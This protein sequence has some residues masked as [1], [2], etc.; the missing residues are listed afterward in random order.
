MRYL[1]V[2]LGAAD[3]VAREWEKR[4]T[5]K[6]R[7]RYAQWA[8]RGGPRVRTV[9]GRNIV[10]RNSVMAVCWYLV[11]NQCPPAL[12]DMMAAW[13]KETWAFVERPRGATLQPGGGG[14]VHA[15]PRA[16]MVQD[17]AEGGARCLDT[18]RFTRALYMRHVR[19]LVDPV[20]QGWK[21]MAMH[22]LKQHYGVLRQGY[23]LLLSACDFLAVL[24]ADVPAFWQNVFVTWGMFDVPVPRDETDTEE[25]DP[26]ACACAQ[27]GF[28]AVWTH[29]VARVALPQTHWTLMRV[30]M[31]P[32]AYNQHLSGVWGARVLEPAAAADVLE[33]DHC[34]GTATLTRVSRARR[35]QARMVLARY[36]AVARA[37]YT[38]VLH[39]LVVDE[40]LERVR[41]KRYDELHVRGQVA[42]M[43]AVV[44]RQLVSGFPPAW[45]EV[46][47]TASGLL[48]ERIQCG[49]PCSLEDLARSFPL[50]KAVW[51][52]LPSGRV[53]QVCESTAVMEWGEAGSA[54]SPTGRLV[55]AEGSSG[56]VPR[57]HLEE[58]HIW[59]ASWHAHSRTDEEQEERRVARGGRGRAVEELVY[60]GLVAEPALL[61]G[62]TDCVMGAVHAGQWSLTYARTDRVRPPVPFVRGC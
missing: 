4:T 10:V 17:Y 60:G 18:E 57:E 42:C 47:D 6:V 53:H 1:G 55:P 39:L 29:G 33:R 16:V 40:R 22:W 30:L 21:G 15:V 24:D 44:Y 49:A 35:E 32:L 38:H 37:G 58:V 31:E 50:P 43:S 19:R 62:N 9:F 34:D 23:R 52:R 46:L 61:R 20:E 28:E 48:R 25:M 51:V 26:H 12:D 11:T 36:T 5:A 41:V 14:S 54:V 13:E 27:L 45:W 59:S 8:M 2:F 56:R 7:A 3:A